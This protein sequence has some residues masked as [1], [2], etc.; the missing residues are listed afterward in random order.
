MGET[1]PLHRFSVNDY[2][3]LIGAGVF[4]EDD[5]V[6]LL[7]GWV[8][9]KM[10]HNP[11]HDSTIDLAVGEIQRLLPP[12]WYPRVQSAITTDDSEPEPDIAV[13]QGPRGRYVQSHPRGRDIGAVIEVSD[14]SL[15]QDR[16]VKSVIYAK[17][18]IPYY[19]II[20]L[21]G[22]CV[23]VY[24]RPEGETYADQQTL[25]KGESLLLILDGKELGTIA[26]D[27]LFPA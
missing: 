1:L 17:A 24:S 8:V 4:T 10:L 20:N 27:S 14:S 5:P 2:H 3:R 22:R 9:D 19:W 23:E 11:L 21:P 7:N 12:P 13:V 18:G 6:E 15:T 26:V 16:D 25:Q